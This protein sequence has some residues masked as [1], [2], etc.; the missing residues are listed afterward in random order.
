M[1]ET[2]KIDRRGLMLVLSSPSG[3]G[4]STLARKLLQKDPQLTL[5]VS[6]TTRQRRGNEVNGTDYEFITQ[7]QF[8]HLRD[9]NQ[10]LEWATVHGNSYGT[11]KEPVEAALRDGRDMLFDI[12][13][14]GTLQMFQSARADIVSVFI[15]PPSMEELRSR[16]VRRAEDSAEVIDRRLAGSLEE[17]K[18]YGA[19]DYQLINDDID[20][21]FDRLRA[22]I[23]AER[24]RGERRVVGMNGFVDGLLKQGRKMVGDQPS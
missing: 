17:L 6:V 24:L 19:Y 3:A 22:I 21:C 15:L 5:S 20:V 16:L 9:D 7:R 12:D 11:P 1:G 18:Q 8:E 10:L 2:T 14:Q 4:K 13:W 23:A